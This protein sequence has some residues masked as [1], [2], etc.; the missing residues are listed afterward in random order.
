MSSSIVNELK[1][2]AS[3]LS[4]L[5]VD[6]EK[7]ILEP[8]YDL[9][10]NFFLRCDTANNGFEALKLYEKN[11]YDIVLTDINMP[12]M[13]GVDLC[14]NIRAKNSQQC[15]IVLS[16]YIDTFVIDLGIS[17]LILKPYEHNKFL[18]LL[19]RNAENITI[20][21]EFNR[22]IFK[23]KNTTKKTKKKQKN[24]SV[25]VKKKVNEDKKSIKNIDT[26]LNKEKI[27]DV[28]S[29]WSIIEDD[30]KDLNSTMTEIIDYIML[31]GITNEYKHELAQM[32]SRYNANLMLVDGLEEFAT[33]FDD[34]SV[35]F[36]K[37]DLDSLEDKVVDNF[38]AY[39]YVYD[40][41]IE[42]FNVIFIKKQT[43]DINYL[44][45][46]LKSSVVQMKSSLSGEDFEEEELEF[47]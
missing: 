25:L 43:D 12:K 31:N 9:L 32:F 26:K 24:T 20:K 29:N 16:G 34:L 27:N 44:T 15:I 19:C 30:I 14:K 39:L 22:M 4:I 33:I 47:F 37:L 40:D 42:F 46:S 5:I 17:G 35:F 36:E 6:D 18:E 1:F 38:D 7:D 21:K 45:D 13:N 11:K 41:L 28:V 23:E 8:I 10:K 2:Y 3:K